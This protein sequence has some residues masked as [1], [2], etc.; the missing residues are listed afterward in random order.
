MANATE[1]HYTVGLASEFCSEKLPRNR[2]GTASVIPRKKVLILRHSKVYGRAYFEARNGRKWHEKNLFYKKSCSSKQK[3]KHVLVRDLVRNGIPSCYLY[4]GTV[5][6]RIPSVCLYF[7]STERNSEY[8]FSSLEWFRTEFLAFAS[9]FVPW[10]RIPSIL[11]LCGTVRNGINQLFRLFRLPLNNFL[12]GN[13]QPYYTVN[14][15]PI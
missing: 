14:F 12:V 15:S 7:C 2:L 8:F 9:N 3:S 1:I 11:L 4:C 10:Y 13:C 5:R 6:N